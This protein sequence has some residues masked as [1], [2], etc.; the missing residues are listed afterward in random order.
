MTLSIFQ[1]FQNIAEEGTAD[2]ESFLQIR[3]SKNKDESADA[4][5]VQETQKAADATGMIEAYIPTIDTKVSANTSLFWFY[6]IV[7]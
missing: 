6:N 1:M 7:W 2:Q 3:D 5:L 4:A